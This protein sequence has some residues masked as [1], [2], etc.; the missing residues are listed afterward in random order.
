MFSSVKNQSVGSQALS[1]AF[2][3]LPLEGEVKTSFRA[4]HE[5]LLPYEGT[6]LTLQSP[7][8]PHLTLYFW[9]TLMPVETGN[10]KDCA[11]KIAAKTEPFTLAVDGVDFFSFRGSPTVL[12]LGISFSEELAR[13]KK[14][15]PWPNERPFHPHVTLARVRHAGRFAVRRKEILKVIGSPSFPV[16]VDRLRLYAK[17]GNAT[18]VPL[19][20]F[21]F[22]RR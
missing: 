3:A 12:F 21:P 2:L 11:R 8:T 22:G 15:F 7:E 5:S 18:Q 4:L 13:L 1:S 9:R 16:H 17:Q 14:S 19:E 6:E 10:V 20:E